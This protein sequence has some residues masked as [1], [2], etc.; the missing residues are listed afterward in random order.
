MRH[1]R[2]RSALVLV[3]TGP[4]IIWIPRVGWTHVAIGSVKF[5]GWSFGIGPWI[6][7]VGRE[8]TPSP[9]STER[10]EG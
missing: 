6:F 4:P 5:T 7:T 2:I 9:S 8:R 10:G 1:L 3:E